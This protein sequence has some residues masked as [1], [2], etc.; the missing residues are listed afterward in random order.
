MKHSRIV[1]QGYDRIAERYVAWSKRLG[2][3]Q[4]DRYLSLL[5]GRLPPGSKVLDL[6]CGTGAL[7]TIR[8]AGS[9]AVTG[10]DI[11]ARS[12]DL[13]RQNVPGAAFVH[14]DMSDLDFPP[15]S[16]DAV[17]AFYT[18]I[19]VPR[20]EHGPLLR[21]IVRWLRPGGLLVATMGAA[22]SSGGVDEDWLGVPMYFS[23]YDAETN[24]RLVRDAGLHI[25]SAREETSDEDGTPVTFLWVV[26][27]KP[28][29]AAV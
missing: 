24:K 17:A 10:V 1:A 14:A 26:A 5:I 27:E 21:K 29:T 2:T 3:E 6:G 4:R 7:T 12:L 11:S 15:G 13:A 18:I 22:S 25:V 23:T 20:E 19:H 8:L 28:K 16:F 9:F